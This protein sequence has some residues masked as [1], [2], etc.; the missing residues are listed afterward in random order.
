MLVKTVYPKSLRQGAQLVLPLLALPCLILA[1]GAAAMASVT[2]VTAAG[3]SAQ[4]SARL[5]EATVVPI[6]DRWTVTLAASPTGL[7]PGQ[8]S[9]LTATANMDVG[10]TPYYLRIYDET[11]GEYVVTCSTGTACS[12]SVTQSAP[13]TDD[14]IAVVSD[15][16]ALYPPGSEQVASAVVPVVWR[17]LS[18]P[19]G[20]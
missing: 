14:Y 10:P 13:A 9:T 19:P 11:T 16:S 4:A 1:G 5:H 3:A 6:K 8:Y 20:R 2:Q 7:L 18:L 15:P 17:Y 12:A